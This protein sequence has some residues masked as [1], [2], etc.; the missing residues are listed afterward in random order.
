VRVVI[1]GGLGLLGRTLA[2]RLGERGTLCGGPI[3]ELVQFD[4]PDGD[5]GD[6]E[7]VT[8]LLR[9]GAGVVFH[10]ASI[11]SGEGEVNFEGALRVN[12]DGT[13]N[14]LETC[15]AL[16]TRPRVVFAS[17]LAVFGGPAM[18][19]T[20][21]D[22]TK[23]TPRTT[24]G[25][26]KSIS[27]LLVNDY[28]RKRYVDGRSARLPT[29]IVRP[30]APNA[31]ASS[32]VSAVFREPLAGVDYVLPVGLQTRMPVISVRTAVDCLVYL[33]EIDGDALGADRA[34]NLPSLCP[35]VE[36]MVESLSRVAGD[37]PL[38]GITVAP[39]PAIEA[40]VRTWPLFTS[41]DRALALGFPRDES[42]DDIVRA[43]IQEYA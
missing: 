32:F 24:Y 11:L 21:S 34:V 30:G 27:E 10:L 4:L 2:S 5:V 29:V 17:T 15:R 35:T 7:Q 40:I 12:L 6:R 28:T 13:R 25:T 39:D 14:V 19:E 16:G 20:V 1:T 8:R 26:T 9:D 22:T 42:L 37:R 3:E 43:Y 18:P 23:Q 33:A 31:A 36:E 41:F 38:G